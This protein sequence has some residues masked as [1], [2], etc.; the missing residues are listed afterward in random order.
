MLRTI[1]P[2]DQS[3]RLSSLSL[4]RFVL[5]LTLSLALLGIVR[6]AAAHAYPVKSVP[7][8][9]DSL[10]TAPQTVTIWFSETVAANQSDIAVFNSDFNQ[11]DS[12]DSHLAPTDNSQLLVS[13]P[14]SLP[15]GT[16]TVRWSAASSMDGHRTTGAFVFAVGGAVSSSAE[17][18]AAQTTTPVDP[19]SAAFGW[20][21]TLSL[22]TLAGVILIGV[23]VLRPVLAA[24][25]FPVRRLQTLLIGLAV[26]S[27]VGGIGSLFADLLQVHDLGRIFRDQLW[28]TAL[29][30]TRSGV[31]WWL[32]LAV[33]V[34]LIG[35]TVTWPRTGSQQK[36]SRAAWLIGSLLAGSLLLT[37]SLNSHS[38]DAL[39]SAFSI[40]VDLAHLLAVSAWIGGLI[41]MSVALP[42]LLPLERWQTLR[43][44]SA[45]ATLCV[46]GVT[47]SGFYIATLHLYR[48]EDL[49]LTDYGRWLLI[50]LVIVAALLLFGLNN[51]RGLRPAATPDSKKKRTVAEPPQPADS[52]LEGV[53]R[54]VI[55]ESLLGVAVLFIV[56]VLA[57][58]GP[59]APPAQMADRTLTQ[60]RSEGDLTAALRV[61]PNAPGRNTYTLHV[62]QNNQPLSTLAQ[63]RVRFILPDHDI[64]TPW[65][66]LTPATDG[67]NIYAAA[68]LEL[69]AI[70]DWQ[71]QID[72]QTTAD[73]DAVRLVFPWRIDSAQLGLDRTQPRQANLVAL[74]LIAAVVVL[75]AWPRL[76]DAL[77]GRYGKVVER[78]LIGVIA[79]VLLITLAGTVVNAAVQSA[80]NQGLPTVNPIPADTA[81]I[82]RGQTV[83]QQVC[84]GCHGAQGLGDGVN[85]AALAVQPANLRVHVPLH[86]DGELFQY[87]TQ[88][89]GA[90]PAVAANLSADQRWDVINY[91]RSIE[92]DQQSTAP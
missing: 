57:S 34:A 51:N 55:V 21:N 29:S 8:N 62:T 25:R 59:P 33:T 79:S 37:L 41:T 65:V 38:A 91:L 81:S 4:R 26:L 18:A 77:R 1:Y 48:L 82:V 49:W 92:A 39:W 32:R 60:F 73:S 67:T 68:G 6:V 61:S 85:A 24:E 2:D 46:I 66:T 90:M 27:I 83:Y 16:Y 53:R 69:S 40:A 30:S 31:I 54:R 23:L 88:G 12:K 52:V 13:L 7:A 45:L 36:R 63:A 80:R 42:L 44:F 84:A 86:S 50:K 22:T 11:V 70:G 58:V 71:A 72:V 35:W 78:A 87:I 19:L 9:G 64:Q 75:I 43:R 56:G 20:L 10:S 14:A 3:R 17:A 89:F 28:W 5:V 74:F 15:N 76:L 47:I